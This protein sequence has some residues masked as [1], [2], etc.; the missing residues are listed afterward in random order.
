MS[1]DAISR[2]AVIK[3]IKGWFDKIELN[4]DIL[5]DSIVTLPPVTPERPKGK[6]IGKYIS[7]ATD[8]EVLIKQWQIAKCNKCG[9]EYKTPY[10]D[11]KF[12]DYA[13]CPNCGAEMSGGEEYE[14]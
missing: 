1:K 9:K 7:G 4:P 14:R 10:T 2:E 13:Y 3:N 11:C 8:Y 5:I 6:W 12:V